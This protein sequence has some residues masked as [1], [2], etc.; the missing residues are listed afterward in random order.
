[1][2]ITIIHGISIIIMNPPAAIT[3]MAR[4]VKSPLVLPVV[5][6]GVLLL[7]GDTVSVVGTKTHIGVVLIVGVMPLSSVVFRSA[8]LLVVTVTIVAVT[9]VA[10]TRLVVPSVGVG[11]II[12]VVTVCDTDVHGISC[13]SGLRGGIEVTLSP[14]VVVGRSLL[15]LLNIVTLLSSVTVGISVL[16]D[17]IPFTGNSSITEAAKIVVRNSK[18]IIFLTCVCRYNLYLS[19]STSKLTQCCLIYAVSL[20]FSASNSN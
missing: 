5:P 7:V 16:L 2:R 20:T 3:A 10:V 6:R 4:M 18:V 9:S 12:A 8:T 1:M 11:L 15:L 19:L 17:T 13:R 14:S